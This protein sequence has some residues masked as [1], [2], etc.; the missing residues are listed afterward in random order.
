MNLEA[1]LC[2][3]TGNCAYFTT[4]PLEKQWGDDWNDAPYESN[5]GSPYGPHKS[6]SHLKR[7]AAGNPVVG[8][9]GKRILEPGSDYTDGL[10]NWEIV[11]IYFEGEFCQPSEGHYNSP[12]SVESIN[13]KA[14]PW[15]RPDPY[16]PSHGI[17]IWAGT[18]VREFMELIEQA[19]GVIYLPRERSMVP[20]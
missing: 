12:Y 2:Y 18:S 7:D 19:G 15:L 6:Y 13:A 8:P 17:S 3:V 9:D 5:A 11:R 4:Q 1:R 20:V 16:G 14:I 10:P